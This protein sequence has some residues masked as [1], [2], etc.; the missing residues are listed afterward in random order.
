M[1]YETQQSAPFT[2][3]SLYEWEKSKKKIDQY[4]CKL[5]LLKV[6]GSEEEAAGNTLH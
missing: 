2:G 4:E 3:A 6:W 1:V 5:K